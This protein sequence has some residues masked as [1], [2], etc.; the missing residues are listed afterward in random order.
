MLCRFCGSETSDQSKFCGS[1]GNAQDFSENPLKS[2]PSATMSYIIGALFVLAGILPYLFR[3]DTVSSTLSLYAQVHSNDFIHAH[4]IF[5]QFASTLSFLFYPASSVIAIYVGFMI[6][7]RR[8]SRPLMITCSVVHFLSIASSII[9]NIMIY[10]FPKTVLSLYTTNTTIIKA[11]ESLIKSYPDALAPY[12]NAAILRLVISAIIIILVIA[13]IR[14]KEKHVFGNEPMRL[15]I[16][17]PMMLIFIPLI[18]L[19]ASYCTKKLIAATYGNDVLAARA[20]AVSVYDYYISVAA[21]FVFVAVIGVSVFACG[22]SQKI[23]KA[24]IA[25][26][27]VILGLITLLMTHTL[28]VHTQTEAQLFDMATSFFTSRIISGVVFLI[29]LL[30]WFQRC[31]KAQNSHLAADCASHST[32]HSIPCYRACSV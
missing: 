4:S 27:V 17:N 15:T 31:I 7:K 19:L 10:S 21:F 9:A 24:C 8:N 12:Q 30:F 26:V 14:S 22:K 6:I 13:I 5:T 25:G 32:P 29:A 2:S 23:I 18:S 11:G 28:F 20:V 16:G 1:C 3:A